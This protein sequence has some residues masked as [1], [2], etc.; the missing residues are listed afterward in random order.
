MERVISTLR[1]M[2]EFYFAGLETLDVAVDVSPTTQL[3][4]TRKVQMRWV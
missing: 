1:L 3:M 4:T 2:V